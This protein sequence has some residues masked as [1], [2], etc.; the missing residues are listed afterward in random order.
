MILSFKASKSDYVIDN[1]GS[2][3]ET[4]VLVDAVVAKLG[5]R[6]RVSRWLLVLLVVPA[7]IALVVAKKAV[8]V[9]F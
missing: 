8:A 3:D 9:L 2:L 5:S 6:T 1:S 7:W 4:R